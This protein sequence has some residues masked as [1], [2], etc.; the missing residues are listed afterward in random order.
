MT[1]VIRTAFVLVLG[2]WL[3][4]STGCYYDDGPF[5]S[6]RS[7]K[8][9]IAN[10]WSFE[11]VERQGLDITAQYV[12]ARLH[13]N[14][15]GTM[16]LE[17]NPDSIGQGNWSLSFDRKL[18]MLNYDLNGQAYENSFI[19]WRLKEDEMWLQ[20]EIGDNLRYELSSN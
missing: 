14:R 7:T 3:L 15:D 19:I 20:E 6:V 10:I 2:G 18:L 8:G 12:D 5:M 11:Y 16:F 13:L 1:N 4:L 9:R 17:F